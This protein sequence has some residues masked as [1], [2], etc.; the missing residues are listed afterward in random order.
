MFIKGVLSASGLATTTLTA[1]GHSQLADVSSN[2]VTVNGDL[3]VTGEIF[4]LPVQ[5]NME[6]LYYHLTGSSS[7]VTATMTL[8]NNTSNTSNYIVIP[9]IYY[10]FSA[11]SSGTYDANATSGALNNIVIS[12]IESTHFKWYL[13]KANNNNVNI[14]IYFMV[15]YGVSDSSFPKGY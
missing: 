3:H 15:L 6:V 14:Y 13:S 1:S 5:N 9:G 10:G 12:D 4:G 7:S 8:L 11:G 2:S